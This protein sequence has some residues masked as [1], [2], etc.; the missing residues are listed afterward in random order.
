[1]PIHQRFKFALLASSILFMQPTTAG[2]LEH[3]IDTQQS[4]ELSS[5]Q[6]QKKIDV[7]ADETTELLV[8]YRTVLAQTES[9][10]SYNQQIDTL[11]ESQ[12]TELA[13]MDEQLTN[14][15]ATQRDILPLMLKMIDTLSQFVELDV[16]F[17]MDERQ[18]RVAELEA[19]MKRADVSLSEKY[20]RILEAYQVE[21]EYGR[22]IEAYQAALI[23]GDSGRTVDFLRI[24][25]VGLYY[26][27]L[28]GR[29]A[30]MWDNKTK[31]WHVLPTDQ[32]QAVSQGLKVALKQ[33][34]PN[35]LVLPKKTEEVEQ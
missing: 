8:E 3:A 12:Q 27:S 30:G 10:Q 13:S 32:N 1:M 31:Q 15:T 29:E 6:T 26:L 21:T 19:L 23:N 33:L 24:G 2:T 11:I 28:D 5:Q 9:I 18:T 20:R 35:L 34:P 14:I 25:R 22:T 17:L 7:L 4:A 16:P